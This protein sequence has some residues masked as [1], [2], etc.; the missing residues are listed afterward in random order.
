MDTKPQIR[1]T[2]VDKGPPENQFSGLQLKSPEGDCH[3]FGD[4][5]P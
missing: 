5:S 3:P 4:E 1:W 2:F